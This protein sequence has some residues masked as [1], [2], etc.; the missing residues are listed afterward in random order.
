MR[1]RDREPRAE[2]EA[3]EGHPLVAVVDPGGLRRLDTRQR[4][5]PGALRDA[6]C[7]GQRGNH[8]GGNREMYGGDPSHLHDPGGAIVAHASE[9]RPRAS[10]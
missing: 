7:P 3:P 10:P 6:G 8:P 9:D 1:E 2:E 5:R 4:G